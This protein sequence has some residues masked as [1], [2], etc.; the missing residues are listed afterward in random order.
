MAML[1][2]I[3]PEMIWIDGELRR[4]LEIVIGP[5]GVIASIDETTGPLTHDRIA[6]LPGFVNAHSHAFQRALRGRGEFFD[7]PESNF[8]SWREAMYELVQ[9]M[10]RDSMKAIASRAFREMRA[11]GM[12]SVGEFHY[13]HHLSLIH[14]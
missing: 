11:A 10:D 6:L 1:D 2:R 12:T 9:E 4:G 13:L 14:I 8:W 5:D 3:R 7:H